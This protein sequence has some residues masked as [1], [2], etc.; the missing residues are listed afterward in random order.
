M[1]GELKRIKKIYGEDFAKLCRSLFP[2]ILED[3]GKLL[4]ILTKNF[5]PTR[6]LCD[7][8]NTEEK[9]LELKYFVYHEAGIGSEKP[10]YNA[11]TPEQLMESVGY[12]LYRCKTDEEVK[13][14]MKYYRR[15]ELL[16]TFN[17]PDRVKECDV[18]FAVRKD[19]EMLNREEF[20][21]PKRE[22]SY[23]TSVISLQFDKKDG[24][25]SIKN[26]YNHTVENPDNTFSNDLDRIVPGL[27]DSFYTH[28]GIE[29]YV[30]YSEYKY[31]GFE[32]FV[33]AHDGKRY[34]YN[35]RYNDGITRVYFCENNVVIN[36][37]N[38]T[39]YDKARYDL[40]DTFLIDK[41]EKTIKNL[42]FQRDAFVE[43]FQDVEKIDAENIEDGLRNIIVTKNDGTYFTVTVNAGN[44]I[45]GYENNFKKSI[46]PYFLAN[47]TTLKYFKMDN[48]EEIGNLFLRHNV[49]LESIVLPKVKR[50]AIDFLCLND[51]L[52]YLDL[53]ELKSAGESFL[54]DN[55]TLKVVK[56]PKLET[57]GEDFLKKLKL[58]K[59]LDMPMIDGLNEDLVQI[60]KSQSGLEME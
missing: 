58:P 57:V 53:P 44:T 9:K 22:D 54:A 18:F 41:S 49:V 11:S 16:C 14:F 46:S 37:G 5:A 42:M 35:Y 8:I 51:K 2:A 23:G 26:R 55:T 47:N 13:Q 1:D 21:S 38:V 60:L 10:K 27:K 29:S 3:E 30:D 28:Y 20:V 52:E 24:E 12:K 43:D 40:V 4:D 45:V 34:K 56:L 6:A 48:V 39:Q 17:D 32:N 19:A 33:K 25:V 7:A 36:G 15:D 59:Q 50:V 31:P